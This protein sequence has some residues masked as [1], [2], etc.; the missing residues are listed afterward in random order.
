MEDRPTPLRVDIRSTDRPVVV[1]EAVGD[2]DAFSA[3]TLRQPFRRLLEAGH[4][5]FVIDLRRVDLL[6]TVVGIR[7]VA[8]V[9][10]TVA[11]Q[12]GTLAL[13][14]AST[15]REAVR[16]AGLHHTLTVHDTVDEAVR[17]CETT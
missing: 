6:D 14:G 3:S 5:R 10:L 13:A 11:A 9:W 7:A 15:V 1:V 8:R 4:R 17:A 16:A 12:D 2:I